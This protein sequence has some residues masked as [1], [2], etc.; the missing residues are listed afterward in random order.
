MNEIIKALLCLAFS[1]NFAPANVK[2]SLASGNELNLTIS[3]SKMDEARRCVANPGEAFRGFIRQ[4]I[5]GAL[6]DSDYEGPIP[7]S[8]C[9]SIKEFNGTGDLE[10]PE[11][12]DKP[13]LGRLIILSDV[14]RV[15]EYDEHK[16][17]GL[18]Y[19]KVEYEDSELEDQRARARMIPGIGAVLFVECP[20]RGDLCLEELLSMGLLVY[21]VNV[22]YGILPDHGNY[23]YP[24]FNQGF[25]EFL[26]AIDKPM[27]DCYQK[28][29]EVNARKIIDRSIL[30]WEVFSAICML[31]IGQDV[32]EIEQSTAHGIG[33]ESILPAVKTAKEILAGLSLLPYKRARTRLVNKPLKPV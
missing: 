24:V 1:H 5:P 26:R 25:A 19:D 15:L 8:L 22:V 6:I 32:E 2:L 21:R 11:D 23:E 29:Y 3:E 10:M 9:M 14:C 12:Y 27:E 33:Y 31:Y 7:N 4:K 17:M 20:R 16:Q 30:P 28:S 18:V 13:I